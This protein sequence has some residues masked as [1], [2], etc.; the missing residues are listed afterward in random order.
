MGGQTAVP[1]GGTGGATTPAPGAGGLFGGGAAPQTPLG[2]TPIDGTPNTQFAQPQVMPMQVMGGGQ[3]FANQLGM[4]GQ[5]AGQPAP[6]QTQAPTQM[7]P[8]AGTFQ[9]GMGVMGGAPQTPLDLN[10]PITEADIRPGSS[11]EYAMRNAMNSGMTM[12][13]WK[14]TGDGRFP[15]GTIVGGKYPQMDGMPSAVQNPSGM[16]GSGLSPLNPQ[17][18]PQSLQSLQG[19][20]PEQQQDA[21]R[22][23][24]PN[25]RGMAPSPMQGRRPSLPPQMQDSRR[26]QFMQRFGNNPNM[27][28]GI[29]S[30]MQRL[31]R[32]VR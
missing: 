28:Q 21:F 8:Q 17:P 3:E 13:D 22:Q 19:L 27:P 23:F 16:G 30:L 5:G 31:G 24:S 7:N 15:V 32:G 29:A 12:A 2:G 4:Y 25:P 1:M 26:Q 6:L 11:I 20:S 9:A 14:S 10:R 18:A